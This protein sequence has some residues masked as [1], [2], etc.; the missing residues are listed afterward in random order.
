MLVVT[1][2]SRPLK[3]CS[4]SERLLV[5]ATVFVIVVTPLAEGLMQSMLTWGLYNFRRLLMR[6]M[7]SL[8]LFRIFALSPSSSGMRMCFLEGPLVMV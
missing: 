7:C 1:R 6:L 5:E 8:A 2:F 4:I 3:Y